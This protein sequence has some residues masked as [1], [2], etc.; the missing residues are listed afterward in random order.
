[1]SSTLSHTL[2]R[3]ATSGATPLA[4]LS[5]KLRQAGNAVWR[6]LEHLGHLRAR[7]ELLLLARQ[8]EFSRPEL[9]AQLRDAVQ[10][11]SAN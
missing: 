9:A 4:T 5:S 3:V 2:P 1:M 7:R 8:Y 6:G 11:N 10:H